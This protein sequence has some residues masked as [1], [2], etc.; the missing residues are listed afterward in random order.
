MNT[1]RVVREWC[2]QHPRL[3]RLIWHPR[4]PDLNII[5][6]VWAEMVCEW[7]PN[8]ATTKD[9]LHECV[10][11]LWRDLQGKPEYFQSLTDS[12]PR[13][14]QKLIHANRGPVNY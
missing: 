1:A 13:R 9:E 6:N 11:D 2:R 10:I 5:E 12:M 4:S 8:M 7:K 14:I 3:Q